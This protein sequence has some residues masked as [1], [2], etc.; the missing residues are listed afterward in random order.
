MWFTL[1][2]Q[3]LGSA[4]GEAASRMDKEEA[5]RLI[6]SV[7][8][9]FGKINLPQLQKVPESKLNG[10]KDD[11][12]YRSHQNA[13]DAQLNDVI[14]SG[15][16]TL[17]GR[18]ALNSLRNKLGRGEA[19]GRASIERNMQARGAL[20]SGNTLAMQLQ[21]N[22]QAAQLASEEGDRMAGM[23]QARVDRAIRERGQQAG[24]G[25]DRT[26]RQESDKARAND[27]IAAGNAA[28][29]NAAA[30]WNARLPQQNFENQMR[31]TS[32][33][34]DPMYTLSDAH[35]AQAKD[36]SQAVQSG[37][38]AAGAAAEALGMS[39]MRTFRQVIM[40]G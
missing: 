6:R 13:A 28:I 4:A 32:A 39:R 5:M 9:E 22:Q 11:P 19:A 12:T 15:G 31:L 29:S 30:Q 26:Y 35:K 24:Q 16:A 34:A 2:A 23:M 7:S 38:N 37:F 40:T 3:V 33:K 25:L 27:A 20:D 18:A 8:D 1:I 21:G 10:I 14:N 17:A 36:T